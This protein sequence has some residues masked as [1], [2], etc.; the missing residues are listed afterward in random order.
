MPFFLLPIIAALGAGAT[1]TATAAALRS[2]SGDTMDDSLREMLERLEKGK[3]M[4]D[5]PSLAL[6]D[7]R[8]IV[9]IADNGSAKMPI[10]PYYTMSKA[11]QLFKFSPNHPIALTAY[12]MAEVNPDSYVPVSEFHEYFKQRKCQAFLKLCA[13]LGAKEIYLESAIINDKSLN[14]NADVK[15][16]LVSLGLGFSFKQNRETGEISAYKFSEENKNIKAYDSPWLHTEPTWQT[17]YELRRESYLK[18]IGAD[19]N[20]VDD[21]GINANLSLTLGLVGANIGGSFHETTKFRLSYRVV[22]W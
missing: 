1:A 15:A 9:I 16:P 19:F 8:I 17:M 21:M 4:I 3:I 12:A 22:F 14:L 18:E 20:Y 2:G 10:I 5:D 7:R 11:K 13:A 6:S